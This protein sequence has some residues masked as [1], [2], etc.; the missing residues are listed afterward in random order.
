VEVVPE[1]DPVFEKGPLLAQ[2][3]NLILI[4]LPEIRSAHDDFEVFELFFQIVQVKDAPG[5]LEVAAL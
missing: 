4:L 1:I 5:G 2:A 3:G